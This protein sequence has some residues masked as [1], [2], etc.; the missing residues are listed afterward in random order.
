MTQSLSYANISI[1]SSEIIK[2]CIK[3]Y[4]YRSRF[5]T[6]FLILLTFFESSNTFFI[7]MVKI[8]MMS[9]KEASAGLLKIKMFQN[10][11]YDVIIPDYVVT[12]K[13]LSSDSNYIR[14][15]AM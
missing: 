13:F 14:D 12:N 8:L 4:R 9:A 2:L 10:K 5:G 3:E 7:N 15:V 1:F 11:G 6:L